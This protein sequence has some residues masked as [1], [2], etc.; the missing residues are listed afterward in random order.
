[1]KKNTISIKP[2]LSILFLILFVTKCSSTDESKKITSAPTP[3]GKSQVQEAINLLKNPTPKNEKHAETLI[4]NARDNSF[5]PKSDEDIQ[6]ELASFSKLP[7]GLSCRV[8]VYERA[9]VVYI[10]GAYGDELIGKLNCN[11]SAVDGKFFSI[12]VKT[13]ITNGFGFEQASTVIL[14]KPK[15]EFIVP[16]QRLTRDENRLD[17]KIFS[18]SEKT[19]AALNSISQK[20]V[21]RI[22]IDGAN[23]HL[24]ASVPREDSPEYEEYS[25]M[26][27]KDVESLTLQ[28]GD[29]SV[30]LA[31]NGR[32][33]L[34]TTKQGENLDLLYGHPNG[35][36]SDGVWSSYLSI[37]VDDEIFHADDLEEKHLVSK[38]ST[39]SLEGKIPSKAIAISIALESFDNKGFVWKA[40]AKNLSNLKPKVG[41][42]LLLDTWAGRTDG[43]P[44]LLPGWTE[45]YP[46]FTSEVKFTP[47]ASPTWETFDPSDPKTSF[48]RATLIGEK[49]SPPN[50]IALANWGSAYGS[51]WEYEVSEETSI[52]GDSAVVSWWDQQEL[53]EGKVRNASLL[54]ESIEKK[55]GIFFEASPNLPGTGIVYISKRN[56]NSE[57]LPIDFKLSVSQG[58][59]LS[60]LK[61]SKLSLNLRAKEYIYKAIPITIVSH[62]KTNLVVEEFEGTT[63]KPTTITLNL[64]EEGGY[65]PLS[66]ENEKTIPFRY[67]S[68][69]SGR[70]IFGQIKKPDGT[71]VSR[72]LLKESTQDTIFVYEGEV[73][74]EAEGEYISEITED[75]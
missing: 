8:S 60:Q 24:L 66:W 32:F 35:Q 65:S 58:K 3:S 72:I 33:T 42:R 20:P 62:G 31:S 37:K 19:V 57:G 23:Y 74:V 5:D 10:E 73:K 44:F 14:S 38:D 17:F 12:E 18:F 64:P 40:S 30:H 68:K 21:N 1:M 67:V 25:R 53:G 6:S 70:K 36:Y 15:I 4:R 13:N 52:T 47:N 16:L 43:V 39:I 63:S 54:F 46:V 51:E 11:S 41:F 50:R 45:T 9:Q 71:S 56:A 2:T 26:I 49:L 59:L 48:L 55:E 28:S 61:D 7:E 27:P 22:E 75:E 29:H 69:T 34:G